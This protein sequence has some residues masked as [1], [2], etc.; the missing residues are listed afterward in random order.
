MNTT[1]YTYLSTA[2]HHGDHTLWFSGLCALINQDRPKLHL[3]QPRI[4][5]SHTGTTDN[6]SMLNKDRKILIMTVSTG[7]FQPQI[8]SSLNSVLQN[9]LMITCNNSFSHCFFRDLYRFSSVDDSSPVSSFSCCSFCNS[10]TLCKVKVWESV[11]AV[12]NS[13]CAF[14]FF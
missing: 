3:G 14:Q 2:Q 1:L 4:T 5:S 10:G 7:F 8:I 12:T 13:R 11:N 9:G 6:V